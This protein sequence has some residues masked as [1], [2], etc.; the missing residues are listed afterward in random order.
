LSVLLDLKDFSMITGDAASRPMASA[1]GQTVQPAAVTFDAP[2]L[3][4]WLDGAS[5]GDLDALPFGVVTMAGDGTVLHYNVWEAELSGLTPER[6]TGRN[7]FTSV[8][9]CTDNVI[10]AHRYRNEVVLDVVIDYV[11]AFRMQGKKV[12]LRLMKRPGSQ[13]MYLVVQ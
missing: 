10:V 12:K 8:A 4:D 5:A 3:M 9:P 13:R 6:V 11:F 2:H 7:F 1:G